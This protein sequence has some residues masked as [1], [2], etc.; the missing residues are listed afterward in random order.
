MTL[1]ALIMLIGAF[2]ALLPFL[3]F[4]NSWDNIMFLI[5][6]VLIVALGIVVRRKLASK[7]TDPVSLR[8]YADTS[9]LDLSKNET[10]Q[11]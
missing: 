2:V 7:H 1:D 6:G 10:E 4:P 3:G 5:A 8:S 11:K 9:M